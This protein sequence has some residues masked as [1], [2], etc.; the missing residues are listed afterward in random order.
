VSATPL[1]AE[2]DLR[3]YDEPV[4]WTQAGNVD[5]VISMGTLE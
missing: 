2:A 1:W 5:V 4:F 3:N